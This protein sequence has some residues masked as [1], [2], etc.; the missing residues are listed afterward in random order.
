MTVALII[1]SHSTQL[2]SGV[3]ELA[4]QTTKGAVPIAPA[5]GIGQGDDNSGAILGTSADVIL[6]AIQ[7]VAGPDGVLVLFDMGSALQSAEMAL[8]MLDEQQRA[9][10]MLTYAPLVEGT[11]AAAVEASLG[12]SLTDVKRAAEQTAQVE[13]LRKLKPITQTIAEQAQHSE[14]TPVSGEVHEASLTLHNPAG[15]HMRPASLFVQTAARFRASIHVQ[16]H[17]KQAD[18]TSIM[19]VLS[20]NA[21]QGDTIVLRATG[22]DAQAALA[23]MATLVHA[24]F[25]E[26]PS[27]LSTESS[28]SKPSL[29]TAVSASAVQAAR[30][31]PGI[32]TF[33]SQPRRRLCV[34]E[35]LK[36]WYNL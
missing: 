32:I 34:N 10:V 7:A 19:S 8:E 21:R 13:Q 11:I 28:V 26:T 6:A 15:L 16:A 3:A 5:G 18:A 14:V 17:G 35:P 4:C 2:A 9:T 24:N 1:V 25:Y 20:L 30:V 27:S 29:A 22:A 23:E 33:W 31:A 12:R 36:G